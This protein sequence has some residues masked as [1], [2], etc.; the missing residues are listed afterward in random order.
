M[1]STFF[2][3]S[4]FLITIFL[5]AFISHIPI[6]LGQC[7][8]FQT[9]IDCKF[10]TLSNCQII[11]ESKQKYPKILINNLKGIFKN[12]KSFL[13]TNNTSSK[14]ES[15]N[16]PPSAS[17][18][19]MIQLSFSCDL[20]DTNTCN[21]GPSRLIPLQDSDGVTRLY[22]QALAKQFQFDSHPEFAPFDILASFTSV[23]NVFW[24][25]DDPSPPTNTQVDFE[26]VVT[27]ELMHGLGFLSSWND[28]FIPYISNGLTPFPSFILSTE[29][30]DVP[31]KNGTITFTGF[32]E[33]AFDRY[34]VLTNGT[35]LS[36]VTSNIN[37]FAGGPNAGTKFDNK[38]AF[39]N[40]FKSSPQ[41][42]FAADIFNKASTA[43]SMAFMT[44]DAKTVNDACLLE[45]SLEPYLS[46]SSIS[47]TDF[48]TFSNSTDFLMIWKAPRGVTLDQLTKANAT[49]QIGVIGPQVIKILET[50]GYKTANNPNPYK[51]N[52]PSLD[53]NNNN[54]WQKK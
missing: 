23:G 44:H 27:H 10:A 2:T 32:Q 31:P 13:T 34:L 33:T 41:F 49:N 4:L 38:T 50:L 45:T 6:V 26:L 15:E 25:R 17:S 29:G 28:F 54:Q 36:T 46:G 5:T 30:P 53:Q 9:I 22:S 35:S 42:S 52:A 40:A 43:S 1:K 11:K 12:G 21:A 47:H 18:Q 48:S 24:F 8:D 7:V 3:G 20:N 37:Q 39:V 51:P 19:N 16:E 14:N